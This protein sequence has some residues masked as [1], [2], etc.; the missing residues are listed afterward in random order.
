[1]LTSKEETFKLIIIIHI[2]TNLELN[3]FLSKKEHY[4]QNC[5]RLTLN[6]VTIVRYHLSRQVILFVYPVLFIGHSLVFRSTIVI[7]H[8]SIT[9]ISMAL[10]RPGK[11]ERGGNGLTMVLA[12]DK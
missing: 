4:N 8:K 9:H 12:P 2:P 6:M 7:I 11:S 10:R 1:M 3:L 5:T